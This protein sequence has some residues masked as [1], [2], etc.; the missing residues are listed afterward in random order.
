MEATLRVIGV[1]A[2]GARIGG[3]LIA[4]K[5]SEAILVQAIRAF[6]E[7]QGAEQVG[8]SGFADPQ[9][10]RALSAFHKEP[11]EAWSVESLAR[12]AGLSRTGFAQHFVKKM[13]VTPMQY[14]TGWR[15]QLA[16]QALAEQGVNVAEAAALSGYTSESA[17]TRVFKKEVGV[18]PA[19]YR[20][21]VA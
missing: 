11:A 19:A 16:R 8:L 9:L 4:L 20:S 14:L 15:M 18:T 6:I 1:E 7:S 10:S 17:F 12:V 5:M 13:A 21:S 3:D 2:G